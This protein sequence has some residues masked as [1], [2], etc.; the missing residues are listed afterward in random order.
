MSYKQ[1]EGRFSVINIFIDNGHLALFTDLYPHAGT[2]SPNSEN[3][4][5][6]EVIKLLKQQSAILENERTPLQ[7]PQVMF[8]AAGREDSKD[9]YNIPWSS[10]EV[11]R[12]TDNK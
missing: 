11:N 3:I 6:K 10:S 12:D 4:L 9:D 7:I 1:V 2:E 5:L 8:L